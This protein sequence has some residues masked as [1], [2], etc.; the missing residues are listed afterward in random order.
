VRRKWS[1]ASLSLPC[2]AKNEAETS[3]CFGKALHRVRERLISQRIGIIN[4]IRAFLLERGIVVHQG[5]RFLRAELPIILATRSDVLPM[6]MLRVIDRQR[7]RVRS[8]PRRLGNGVSCSVIRPDKNRVSATAI[9]DQVIERTSARSYRLSSAP[10]VGRSP[11][12]AAEGDAGTF[13][14]DRPKNPQ[15]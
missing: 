10:L 1:L 12:C 4:Q 11:P 13:T 15:T 2:R 7:R 5:L 9:A 8:R 14:L 6:R 3:V